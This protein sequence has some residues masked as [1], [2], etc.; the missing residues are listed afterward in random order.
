MSAQTAIVGDIVGSDGIVTA[1]T[2]LTKERKHP[3]RTLFVH[4]IGVVAWVATCKCYDGDIAN[5]EW[6][7]L[8][9]IA[10][11]AQLRAEVMSTPRVL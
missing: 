3:L 1:R 6:A 9:R 8:R 7:K 4:R 11:V 10:H 5:P 2:L